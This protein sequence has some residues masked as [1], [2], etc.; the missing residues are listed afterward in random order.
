MFN[1]E[2]QTKAYQNFILQKSIPLMQI[3][4]FVG[5]NPGVIYFLT[6]L[7]TQYPLFSSIN[8]LS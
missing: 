1:E 6:M 8:H 4:A 3:Y 2:K 5:K 7:Y